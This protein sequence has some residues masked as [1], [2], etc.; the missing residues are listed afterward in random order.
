M[1][2]LLAAQYN[3]AP[4][5]KTASAEELQKE[6]Q[7]EYFY[8]VAEA[9]SID[10]TQLSD[11]QLESLWSEVWDKVAEEEQKDSEE[12]E[13]EK[14]K[15]EHE[16]KRAH[17]ELLKQADFIGRAAA[18]AMH[19]ELQKLAAEAG[20]PPQFQP[21][22][23]KTLVGSAPFKDPRPLSIKG[24]E[25]MKEVGKKVLEFAKKHKGTAAVGAGALALGAGAG[26]LASRKK[27]A[28]AF[29]VQAA[30]LAF[31]YGKEAYPNEV[32]SLA[33]LL[34]EKLAEGG[35]EEQ[36]K[37]ASFDFETAVHVRAF[38]FLE[39]IGVPVNWSKVL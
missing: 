16:E 33:A 23:K 35:I 28:S 30:K 8:K 10:L 36:N 26:A 29:D 7:L 32:D 12:M 9:N 4:A 38:E 1:N 25:K 31:E 21:A 13:K 39:S 27:E 11:Q 6:A 14:A 2:A 5:E 19:D 15:K 17:E 24:K 20:K 34:D 22:P 3:N 18:H 37:L